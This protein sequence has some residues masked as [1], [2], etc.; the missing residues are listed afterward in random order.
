MSAQ[1]ITT[2]MQRRAPLIYKFRA[3]VRCLVFLVFVASSAN[4]AQAH[5]QVAANIRVVHVEHAKDG[6]RTY[7]RVPMALLVAD[8]LGPVRG[9]GSRE[10]APFTTNREENGQLVHY[11]D[12]DEVLANPVGLG[13]V[14]ADKHVFVFNGKRVRGDVE[15]VRVWPAL[16]QT[17]FV[18]LE[19]V[20]R[21]FLEKEIFPAN[22]GP[23]YVGDAVVDIQLLYRGVDS[24]NGFMVA[25]Q[26]KGV[27]PNVDTLANVII[28]HQ[29]G[30]P[31]IY[32]IL[33]PI[34]ELVQI[35]EV[36]EERRVWNGFRRFRK[37]RTRRC[38][39]RGASCLKECA[40][41]LP[42]SIT[43]CSSYAS[44]LVPQVFAC[45]STV[46][47]DSRLVIPLRLS[48]GF[49]ATHH[50]VPGLIPAV[51]LG[52]ALSIIY[53]AIAAMTN[54]GEISSFL[55]TTCIGL[56]HGLGFSFVLHEIL[57]VDSPNLWVSLISF[58]IGVEI[59]QLLVVVAIWPA[60]VIGLKRLEKTTFLARNAIALAALCV[61]LYWSYQRAKVLDGLW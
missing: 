41:Y 13:R 11:V 28:H 14:A 22:A 57:K 39:T 43:C 32:R 45:W 4:V 27:V 46:F 10:P 51:E 30:E 60:F 16:Q 23:T 15:S 61:A 38:R 17:R 19:E 58:N 9:D 49:S 31:R 40:T 47:R 1:G 53:A 34:A 6:I 12:L 7:M 24:V 44:P 21:S 25:T 26:L 37:R 50:P 59:G 18:S 8:L 55:V 48:V 36:P 20:K 5:F 2:H 52:I 33:G 35:G 3:I 56:V 29:G 42:G 54:R